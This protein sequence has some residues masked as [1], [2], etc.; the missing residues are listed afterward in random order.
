[1]KKKPNNI[2][3]TDNQIDDAANEQADTPIDN[4]ELIQPANGKPAQRGQALFIVAVLVIV[5]SGLN[6]FLTI[7]LYGNLQL[8]L[9]AVC[10][11]L[12]IYLLGLRWAVVVTL[13]I[14]LSLG[15]GLE[16]WFIR[17]WLTGFSLACRSLGSFFKNLTLA[18]SNLL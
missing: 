1:L 14:G 12:G 13:L 3:E 8:H 7:P 17:I 2:A 6:S 18:A 11:V 16:N 15:L 4:Y 5:G 10:G 9:G